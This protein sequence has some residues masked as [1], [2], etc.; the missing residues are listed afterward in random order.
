MLV[1][2]FVLTFRGTTERSKDC[3]KGQAKAHAYTP[4]FSRQPDR[5][6]D[7]QAVG[8]CAAIKIN[9]WAVVRVIHELENRSLDHAPPTGERNEGD[10]V[11]HDNNRRQNGE[12]MGGK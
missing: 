10:E 7:R 2:A 4:I 8:E 6:A 12:A 1:A 11:N 3:R 5:Q 9:A